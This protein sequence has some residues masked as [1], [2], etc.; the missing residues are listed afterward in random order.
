MSRM[1]INNSAM[2]IYIC[3]YLN[4]GY[5]INSSFSPSESKEITLNDTGEVFV[6]SDYPNKNI[7]FQYASVDTTFDVSSR[8]YNIV[9]I[10][11]I[12][13]KHVDGFTINSGGTAEITVS[14]TSP[15]TPPTKT[16]DINYSFQILQ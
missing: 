10:E 8:I 16:V 4:G 13:A 11:T 15:I 3:E 6:P 7:R 5:H 1:I 9:G 2:P 14:D 12:K